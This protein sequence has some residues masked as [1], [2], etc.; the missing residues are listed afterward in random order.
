MSDD[1]NAGMASGDDSV[2]PFLL[3]SSGIRGRLARLGPLADTI[4]E[5]HNY[6]EPVAELL[7]ELLVL[8]A[9][10]SSLM[11]YDG[12]FTLQTKGD[13][14]VGMMVADVTTE[15]ILRGFAGYDE[16]KLAAALKDSDQNA[17][18]GRQHLL[19][20]GYIAFTVDQGDH[21]ERYQGIVELTGE[22]LAESVQHYF[23]QSD[24]IQ[25]G[26]L[27]AAGRV[28]GAW[29]ASALILQSLPESEIEKALAIDEDAWRRAMVLQASCSNDELLSPEL[30]MND[31]LFRLFHEEGVRVFKSRP[32][33]AGCRCSRD[34]LAM[35]L[36]SLPREEIE[37]LKVDG[38]VV[39]TCEFCTTDYRFDEATLSDIYAP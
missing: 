33:T 24:Q 26:V 7:G 10:L 20:S 23:R 38:E 9:A 17:D 5:R 13:G 37:E 31:L 32:V 8:A 1:P 3:E 18:A 22:S 21:T 19:G 12:I 25:A 28:A 6:P 15:G 34:R 29:R 36:G 35:V 14:P 4:I 11:K 2:L 27:L 39:I 30:P 16:E